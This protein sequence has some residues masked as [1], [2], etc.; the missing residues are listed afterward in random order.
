MLRAERHSARMS[1]IKNI[2][3][4]WMAKCNQL[5]P[6]PFKGFNIWHIK[7]IIIDICHVSLLLQTL[8]AINWPL[9]F[10]VRNL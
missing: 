3:L 10:V 7:L 4:T 6:L 1:E 2:G 9:L 8:V 5:T